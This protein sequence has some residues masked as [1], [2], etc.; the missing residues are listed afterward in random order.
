MLPRS[1]CERKLI[2]VFQM[3]QEL[4][5][6][7]QELSRIGL[8]TASVKEKW[9][10]ATPLSESCHVDMQPNILSKSPIWSRDY[11]DF[12]ISLVVALV[13]EKW[14]LAIVFAGPCRYLSVCQTISKYLQRFE[15]FGHLCNTPLV[16]YFFF[17]FFFFFFFLFFL[18][19][20]QIS[21]CKLCMLT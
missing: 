9:Y 17:F 14:P 19:K 7:A 15:P 8:G 21:I 12:H 6:V 1:I 4:L 2:K 11:G 10:L 5:A 18:V 3:F 20:S 16:C 13:K